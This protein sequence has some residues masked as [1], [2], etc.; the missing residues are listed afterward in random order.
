MLIGKDWK[1]ETDPMNVLLFRR[2][3]AD[4]KCHL[5]KVAGAERWQIFGYFADIKGV[6]HELVRQGVRDAGLVDL[7]VLDAKIDN[8]HQLI[9]S[10]SG[11]LQQSTG[12]SKAKKGIQVPVGEQVPVEDTQPVEEDED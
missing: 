7:R 9:E 2:M 4:P 10:L 3:V 5:T 11:C 1:I 12:R 6:L 8:L